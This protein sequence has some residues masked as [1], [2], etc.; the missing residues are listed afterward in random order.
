MFAHAEANRKH[1][2]WPT[3]YLKSLLPGN[4]EVAP[5]KKAGN[6]IAPQMMYPAN[7]S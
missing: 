5:G 2:D 1:I 7:L 6:G 3:S 4:P